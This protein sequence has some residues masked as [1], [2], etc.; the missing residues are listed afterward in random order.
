[1]SLFAEAYDIIYGDKDY[2]HDIAVF[3][4][5][6]RDAYAT[7]AV[8]AGAHARNWRGHRQSHAAYKLVDFKPHRGREDDRF[9]ALEPKKSPPKCRS[10]MRYAFGKSGSL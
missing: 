6:L 4:K 2:A 7:T 10:E 3:V 8:V 5:T 9:S 1:M